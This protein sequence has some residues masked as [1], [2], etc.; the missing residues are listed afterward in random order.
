MGIGDFNGDG[1][2]DILWQD[3]NTGTVAYWLL[4]SSTQI[5]Q[6]GTLG[7]VPAPWSISLTGDYN[8]DGYAD[9]LWRNTTTGDAVIWFLVPSLGDV[10]EVLSGAFIGNVATNWTIQNA[11]AE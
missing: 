4:I 10:V 11:N 5:L 8:G 2:M 3:S 7:A 9:I 1:V 6:T